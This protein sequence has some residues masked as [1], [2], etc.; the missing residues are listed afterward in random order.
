VN[1]VGHIFTISE[2]CYLSHIQEMRLFLNFVGLM[3]FTFVDL[4]PEEI[5]NEGVLTSAEPLVLGPLVLGPFGSLESIVTIQ[6]SL[7]IS[8]QKKPKRPTQ[9]SFHF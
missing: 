2:I 6:A 4:Y 1:N 8:V 3:S 5:Q 7:V 9:C